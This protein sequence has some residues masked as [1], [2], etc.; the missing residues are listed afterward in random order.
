MQFSSSRAECLYSSDLLYSSLQLA[1]SVSLVC[2][3]DEMATSNES[4]FGD[5]D[6]STDSPSIVI[7]DDVDLPPFEILPRQNW[8]GKI[9]DMGNVGGITIVFGI[10][11]VHHSMG[12]LSSHGPL[13]ETH[14][15]IQVSRT[16][17]EEEAPDGWRYC[18]R[19]CL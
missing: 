9:V 8:V 17:V 4:S 15:A 1:N 14:V 19:P 12:V 16:F 5:L 6:F 3:S 11:R 13:C 7:P 18:V 10:V 2:C